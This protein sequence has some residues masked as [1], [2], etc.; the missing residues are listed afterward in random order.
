MSHKRSHKRSKH[1]VNRRVI[2]HHI[3]ISKNIFEKFLESFHEN[4][5][6]I[7]FDNIRDL[8]Y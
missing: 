6:D 3:N 5:F 1:F 4:D 2:F 7:L 8:S